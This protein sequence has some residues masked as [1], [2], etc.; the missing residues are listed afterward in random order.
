MIQYFPKPYEPF[1]GDI[2]VKVDLSN[3]ATKTDLKDA[4]GID[5]SNFALKSN[6]SSLK[7][8]VDKLNIDK[9][10]PFLVDLS[11]VSD[12]LVPKVNNIDTTGFVLK[13]KYDK[14]NQT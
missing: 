6:L 11:K 12:K 3:Y 10:A 8:E 4:T 1:R 2:N 14:I 13:T 9:L 7:I 5:T